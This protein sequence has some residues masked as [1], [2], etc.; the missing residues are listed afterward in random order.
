[1][2][3]ASLLLSTGI[4]MSAASAHADIYGYIDAGGI[5]HFST[6]KLDERYRLFVKGNAPFNSSLLPQLPAEEKAGPFSD[7]LSRHP[8]LLK[9]EPLVLQAAQE[10]ALDPALLKAVMAAE[11]GFNPAAVSP[12]GA[13]GLMQVMP[14]TAERYG[15]QADRQRTIAQ[16]LADPKTNIRLAARYLRDLHQMFPLRLDLVIAAYNA[17]ENAVQ[18]YNHQIPPYRETR[19]YVKLVSQFYRLYQPASE[20]A[21]QASGSHSSSKRIHMT[22]PGRSSMPR[23]DIE[24]IS[25]RN[26]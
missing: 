5:A 4:A 13:I 21:M 24:T 18:K 12:K 14:A 22:I 19:N 8:N 26:D 1:M 10:F 6:E 17:G 20:S 3:S 11:S 16:K 9:F 23:P 2:R 15:L 25:N 7:Y